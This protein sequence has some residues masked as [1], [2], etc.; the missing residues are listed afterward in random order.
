MKN[1]NC[2][3]EQGQAEAQFNLECFISLINSLTKLLHWY[4]LSAN[5]GFTKAQINLGLMYQQGTGVELDEKQMLHWMKIA[6]ES[7]DPIGQMNM[8]EYTLYG[9]NDLLEKNP[10]KAERW[11]KSG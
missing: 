4:L 5:Q 1:A 9:I 11:L 3:A 6:T 2:T 10:E 7:G 8:A